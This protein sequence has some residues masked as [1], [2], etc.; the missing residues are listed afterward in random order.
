M[1]SKFID[2][3][4]LLGIGYAAGRDEI[5]KAYQTLL[6][7]NRDDPTMAARLRE[8]WGVLGDRVEREEYDR[9]PEIRKRRR[10]HSGY[11]RASN[12]SAAVSKTQIISSPSVSKTQIIS[13]PNI[14]EDT[15]KT[16]VHRVEFPP[17]HVD[18]VSPDG[19]TKSFSFQQAQITIGRS[20]DQ[21]IVLP[22]K[23]RYVSRK[24][25]HIEVKGSEFYLTDTS[26]NGTRLNGRKITKNQKYRLSNGDTIDIESWRLRVNF[27]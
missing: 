3:Y 10:L 25:A 19:S 22:D 18:V 11:N 8:A 5:K 17:I 12:R 23:E 21:D 7:K 1:G 20:S 27:K 26:T 14:G 13:N 9:Q 24:H 15:S 6:K 2:Y 4:Q 16:V